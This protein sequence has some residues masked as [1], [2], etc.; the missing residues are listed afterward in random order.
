MRIDPKKAHETSKLHLRAA[1]RHTHVHK[2]SCSEASK[3]PMKFNESQV[4]QLS[5]KMRTAHFVAKYHKSFLDYARVFELDKMKGL[6]I[7]NSYT[8]NKEGAKLLASPM[9]PEGALLKTLNQQRF[10]HLLVMGRVISLV[11]TLYIRT[12]LHGVIRVQILSICIAESTSAKYI[13]E[14][15]CSQLVS[16]SFEEEMRNKLVGFCSGGI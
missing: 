16:P 5:I 2:E 12:C 4:G 14:H 6:D 8:S 9:S 10:S 11:T 13:H 7:E 15:I 1:D 3:C